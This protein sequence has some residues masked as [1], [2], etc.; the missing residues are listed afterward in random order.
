MHLTCGDVT[1]ERGREA[2][3]VMRLDR[4]LVSGQRQEVLHQDRVHPRYLHLDGSQKGQIKS[5]GSLCKHTV[6]WTYNHKSCFNCGGVTVCDFVL[7]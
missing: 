1:G 3:W 4:D 5:I 6:S 7:M 2:L